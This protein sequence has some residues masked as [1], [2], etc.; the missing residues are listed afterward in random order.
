[1]WLITIDCRSEVLEVVA[2]HQHN[3]SEDVFEREPFSVQFST[4]DGEGES[5]L[6]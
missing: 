3:D 2:I 1:M 4:I 5:Q 6:V